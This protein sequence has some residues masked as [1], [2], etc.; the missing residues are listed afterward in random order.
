MSSLSLDASLRTCKVDT[1]DANRMESDRFL[2]PH[3]M[4]CIPW[5]GYNLKGQAVCS[6]SFYTKRPGCN[7]AVDRVDVESELRPDYAAYVNLNMGGIEGA[8]YGNSDNTNTRQRGGHSNKY[9][10]SRR[11]VG[12]GFNNDFQATN[13]DTCRGNAYEVAMAQEQNR[14]MAHSNNSYHSYKKMQAANNNSC[15]N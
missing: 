1:G 12:G 3:N 2:N 4:A 8:I 13:Y 10:E 15:G 14:R 11:T 6:D 7:S 5:N 9:L